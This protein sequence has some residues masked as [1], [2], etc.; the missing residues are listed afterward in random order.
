[1]ACTRARERL[2]V[3][4]VQSTHEDGEVASRFL[5]ELRPTADEAHAGAHDVV[6]RH[7]QGRPVRPLTLDGVVAHLRRTVADPETPEVLRDAAARRLAAL[8]GEEMD[9]RP[10]VPAADPRHWWGTAGLTH[11]DVP[12][13]EVEVP[14]KVS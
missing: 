4:A 13:R 3:T 8:A 9:G 14:V 7:E 2:V 5:D 1:V 10:L 6:V 12:V 11:S